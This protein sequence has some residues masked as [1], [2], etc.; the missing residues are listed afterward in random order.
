VLQVRSPSKEDSEEPAEA[1]APPRLRAMQYMTASRG[2]EWKS[3]RKGKSLPNSYMD[4]VRGFNERTPT[5]SLRAALGTAVSSHRLLVSSHMAVRGSLLHNAVCLLASLAYTY[6]NQ[7]ALQKAGGL[8]PLVALLR[9]GMSESELVKEAACDAL[10]QNAKAPANKRAIA[11]AGAIE[12][13][14]RFVEVGTLRQ[15]TCAAGCLRDLIYPFHEAYREHAKAI[16]AAG[17]IAALVEVAQGGTG[18]SP[19]G[20]AQKVRA[21]DAL[22]ALANYPTDKGVKL[23]KEIFDMGYYGV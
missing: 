16:V 22:R 14:V 9:G 20:H 15:K 5:E 11:A 21:G 6:D 12:Q 19:A 23:Q 4:G 1:P 7:V 13:L 10:W 8:P 17:G 3:Q 18:E 2:S